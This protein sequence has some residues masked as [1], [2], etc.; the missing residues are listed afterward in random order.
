M[1]LY[2]EGEHIFHYSHPERVQKR[3]RFF[4][5]VLPPEHPIHQFQSA[6][7]LAQLKVEKSDLQKR[8]MRLMLVE[9]KNAEQ[10]KE[11]EQLEKKLQEYHYQV[12]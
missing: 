4:R 12:S 3:D 1:F 10:A 9:E 11:E 8:F 2:W 7:E 6:E 5:R